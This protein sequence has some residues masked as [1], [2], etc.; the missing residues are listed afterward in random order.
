MRLATAQRV[1]ICAVSAQIVVN[2]TAI[3]RLNLSITLLY[4]IIVPIRVTHQNGA[5]AGRTARSSTLAA[6]WRCGRTRRIDADTA[7]ASLARP[8]RASHARPAIRRWPRAR[9]PLP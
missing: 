7:P 8:R 9:A 5:E 3:I 4:E 1:V 2:R 6:L